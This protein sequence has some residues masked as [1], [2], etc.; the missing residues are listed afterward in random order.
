M[1]EMIASRS[2]V[3]W[4]YQGCESSPTATLVPPDG[5]RLKKLVLWLPAGPAA[6]IVEDTIRRDL[7]DRELSSSGLNVSVL[8]KRPRKAVWN[9]IVLDHWDYGL[10]PM[11]D[12]ED[13]LM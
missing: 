5:P 13:S 12:S 6:D 11:L 2:H 8:R 9:E 7:M 3:G 10:G 1:Y 4:N